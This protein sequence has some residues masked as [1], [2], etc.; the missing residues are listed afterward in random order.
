MKVF[1]MFEVI[2]RGHEKYYGISDVVR[3]FFGAPEELKE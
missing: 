1:R 2:L 3:M